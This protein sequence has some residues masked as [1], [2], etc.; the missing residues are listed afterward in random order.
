MGGICI[1]MHFNVMAPFY[2]DID[3]TPEYFANTTG[4]VST[5]NFYWSSRMI[6]AMADASYKKVYFSILSVT[7]N[8]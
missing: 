1:K 6:A 4:E 5:E 3:E 7:R 8:M 2:A